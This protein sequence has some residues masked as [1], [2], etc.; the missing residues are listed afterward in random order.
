MKFYV[1]II[2]ILQK[3]FEIEAAT[4]EEAEIIVRENYRNEEDGYVLDGSCWVD[5]SYVV[6]RAGDSL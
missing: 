2:E 6:D 5:T 4:A 1:G 3:D